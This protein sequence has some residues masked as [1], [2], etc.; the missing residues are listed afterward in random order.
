MTPNSCDSKNIR[1]GRLLICVLWFWVFFFFPF[2][3]IQFQVSLFWV[4]SGVLCGREEGERQF[5]YSFF[6]KTFKYCSLESSVL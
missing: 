4:I 6:L 1:I 5:H 2:G 3:L